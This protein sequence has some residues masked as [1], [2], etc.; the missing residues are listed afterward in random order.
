MEEQLAVWT[1]GC[2][3]TYQW[4]VGI[5]IRTQAGSFTVVELWF[6][7]KIVLDCSCL[8]PFFK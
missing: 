3:A 4:E 2:S 1:T 5:I 7:Y 6:N 8:S